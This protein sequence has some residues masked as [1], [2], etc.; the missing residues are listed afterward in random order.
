MVGNKTDRSSW[1]PGAGDN[2]YKCD[3]N[4][5]KGATDT[6]R[7]YSKVFIQGWERRLPLGSAM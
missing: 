2:S 3:E 7:V 6:G 1:S 4:D 5:E